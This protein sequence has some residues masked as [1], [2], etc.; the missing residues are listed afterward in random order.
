MSSF[1]V[2]GL[3]VPVTFGLLMEWRGGGALVPVAAH[4]IPVAWKLKGG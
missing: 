3:G 1:G 2:P 4:L